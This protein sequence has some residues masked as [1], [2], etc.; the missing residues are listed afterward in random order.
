MNANQ[1]VKNILT[2]IICVIIFLLT[3]LFIAFRHEIRTLASLEE[4]SPGAY[5]M[6]YDGD[7]GFDEFLAAGANDDKQIEEFITKHLLKGIPVNLNVSGAGCTSFATR[8]VNSDVIFAR[9]FDFEYSPFVQVYTN[10][11]KG[12][13]SVSTVNLSFAGYSKNNLPASGIALKNFLTLAAPFLPFDGMNE[14]GVCIALLSVPEAQPEIDPEKIT[15]NTTTS[16]RLVLDKAANVDE[17]IELLRKYNIFFSGNVK[18]HFHIA[19]STGRS[20]LVEYYDGG[21]QVVEPETDY[22]IASNYIAY[23]DLNIGEGF[24]EF[25][26]YNEVKTALEDNDGITL[27]EC[28]ELLNRIGIVYNGNDKL[29][30]SVIYNLTQGNGEIWPHRNHDQAWDFN[31]IGK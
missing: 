29:Q 24:T 28:E 30:W 15:L 10:P 18:C 3:I 2:I 9:N 25:E 26:R 31:L 12:Y 22:Q 20:V 8:N 27:N 11:E 7:Y 17:A 5:T 6:V 1:I 21:L 14:K 4:R 16:I 23:N 19:D 13:A